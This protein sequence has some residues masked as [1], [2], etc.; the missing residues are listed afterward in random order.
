MPAKQ[1]ILSGLRTIANRYRL[2]ALLLHVC[3]YVLILALVAKWAPAERLMSI[4]LC[5]PLITVATFA[6]ITGNPFNGFLFT[7]LS[8]LVLITGFTIPDQPVTYSNPVYLYIG[9]YMILFGMVYPH[10]LSTRSLPRYLI[11]SPFGLIPCPTLSVVIGFLLIFNGLGSPAITLA[12]AGFGLFYGIFGT[13]KLRVYLDIFL[14]FGTVVLLV[15]YL[16][17]R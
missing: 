5:L 16:A 3:F 9:I 12:L 2:W 13:L 10:F 8:V 7:V 6:L 15:Q 14:I 11:S 4:I 17:G 1:E